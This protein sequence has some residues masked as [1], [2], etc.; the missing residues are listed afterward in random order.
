MSITKT[1]RQRPRPRALALLPLLG[2][3][4]CVQSP[5][6]KQL[7]QETEHIDLNGWAF[8]KS[9]TVKVELFNLTTSTW[10]TVGSTTAASSPTTI[11]AESLYRWHIRVDLA[12]A[13][14]TSVDYWGSSCNAPEAKLRVKEIG[15]NRYLPTFDKGG[16]SCVV[17]K[18]SNGVDWLIAG[19]DCASP[20]SPVITLYGPPC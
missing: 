15:I 16:I 4:A 18:L 13:P 11:G 8:K 1:R 19:R 2:L 20:E 6:N 3:L 5:Y 17:S 14:G 10:D 9:A 7:T 12:Q